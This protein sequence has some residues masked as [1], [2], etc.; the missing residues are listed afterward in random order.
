MNQYHCVPPLPDDEV[1]RIISNANKYSS[2]ATR[3]LFM[4][5]DWILNEAPRDPTFRHILH[6]LSFYMDVWGKSAYPTE[7]Q[8]A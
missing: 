6:V 1:N 4:F 2:R 3:P 7:D 5:R 8:I